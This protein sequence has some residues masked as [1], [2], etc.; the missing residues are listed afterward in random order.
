LVDTIY[1]ASDINQILPIALGALVNNSQQAS[2]AA[3]RTNALHSPLA[4]IHQVTQAIAAQSVAKVN[5][6]KKE[7][8][9][10]I[11]KRSEPNFGADDDEKPRDEEQSIQS[12]S[13]PQYKK[14][15]GNLDL[16]A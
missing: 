12:K 14:G 13:K 1:V 3:S 15:S 7:Q 5:A 11:P 6:D 2:I 16:V 4:N 8:S 10:Q 9:V